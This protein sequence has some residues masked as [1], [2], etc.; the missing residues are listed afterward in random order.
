MSDVFKMKKT[1]CCPGFQHNIEAVGQRGIAIIVKNTTEGI[2]F[3]LQSR[4]IAFEDEMKT[5][6]LPGAS[7]MKINVSCT[8]GL[9]YC[10]ACGRRLQELVD[11]SRGA[12]EELAEKHRQF[13][14]ADD[15]DI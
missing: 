14:S 12:F 1:F 6:P 9:L 4:G 10:P 8:T 11:A 2:T 7:D 3:L 5:R 15:W 13:L